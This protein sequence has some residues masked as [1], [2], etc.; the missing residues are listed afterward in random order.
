M[1]YFWIIKLFW[2]LAL[3]II[4]SFC[5]TSYL[6]VLNI[7]HLLN[8]KEICYFFNNWLLLERKSYQWKIRVLTFIR[9]F[10][11]WLKVKLNTLKKYPE[12]FNRFTSSSDF[13]INKWFVTTLS[14]LPNLSLSPEFLRYF[15]FKETP[16]SLLLSMIFR[17]R[18]FLKLLPVETH[19]LQFFLLNHCKKR[20][21]KFSNGDFLTWEPLSVKLNIK[22]SFITLVL[23]WPLKVQRDEN[24]F[25]SPWCQRP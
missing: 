12:V 25:W 17:L 22:F 11:I 4:G 14:L 20:N 6:V 16:L 23:E 15:P 21:V 10:A 13:T 18:T 19:P 24:F 8:W 7:V 1:W 3:K 5:F 2:S 9:I